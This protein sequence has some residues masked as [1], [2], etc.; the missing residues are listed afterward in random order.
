MATRLISERIKVELED[1]PQGLRQPVAFLWRGKRFVIKRILS[2]LLDVG[3]GAG[4]ITR[5]W[6]RR[7]H[8]N[9]FRVETEEGEIFE[10]YLD[11]SGSRRDWILKRQIQ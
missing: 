1:T 2:A 4:E 8:R 3:F 9:Y 5:T 6:Y 11:R 10:I 7:R